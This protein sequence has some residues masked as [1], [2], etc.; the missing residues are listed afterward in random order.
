MNGNALKTTGLILL[1]A[2]GLLGMLFRVQHWPWA[3]TLMWVGFIGFPLL[4][5]YISWP[6]GRGIPDGRW[7]GTMA[8]MLLFALIILLR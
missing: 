1:S 4:Y 5:G 8:T 3:T 7:W 6:E 2:L